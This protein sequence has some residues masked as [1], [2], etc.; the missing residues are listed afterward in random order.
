MT[1]G[2]ESPLAT[3]PHSQLICFDTVCSSPSW[4]EPL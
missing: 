4:S 3:Y 1:S 2:S